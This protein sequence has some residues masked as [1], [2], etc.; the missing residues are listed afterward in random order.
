MQGISPEW[1]VETERGPDWVFMRLHGSEGN[2][3]EKVWD[4]L[5]KGFVYRVVLEFDE[6]ARMQSTQ[7]GQLVDL[8]KRISD[9]SGVLRLCGLSDASRSALAATKLSQQLPV[10]DCR[11]DAVMGAAKPR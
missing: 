10:F 11:H 5:Q 7:I 9:H 6:A 3:A 1:Q 4:V 2:L 8:R